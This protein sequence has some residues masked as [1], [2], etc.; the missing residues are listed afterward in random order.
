MNMNLLH[1]P[2]EV[3]FFRVVLLADHVCL[4][5]YTVAAI[6][7]LALALRPLLSAR[8]AGVVERLFDVGAWFQGKLRRTGCDHHTEKLREYV[9]ERRVRRTMNFS[10]NAVH[11]VALYSVCQISKNRY[12]AFNESFVEEQY[13]PKLTTALSVDMTLAFVAAM[14]MRMFPHWVGPF[15][16]DFF[17]MVVVARVAWQGHATGRYVTGSTP[18]ESVYLIMRV[19]SAVLIGNPGFTAFLNTV[20]VASRLFFYIQITTGP[21]YRNL[22]GI[23][24][25]RV[26]VFMEYDDEA[27]ALEKFVL[28]ECFCGLATVLATWTLSDS[29]WQEGLAVLQAKTASRAES[30]STC[31]LSTLCDAVVPTSLNFTLTTPSRQLT[32]FFMRKPLNDTYEGNNLLNLFEEEDRAHVAEQLSACL[33]MPGKT[34]SAVARAVDGGG[35]RQTARLYCTQYTDAEDRNG[36][37]IGI[38][39]ERFDD[40]VVDQ[41]SAPP[42]EDD[43]SAS[44]QTLGGDPLA[45]AAA[46]GSKPAED[47]CSEDTS[48]ATSTKSSNVEV[49]V[50]SSGAAEVWIDFSQQHLPIL[51][52]SEA[53]L[54]LMGTD[55]EECLKGWI[56]PVELNIMRRQ[57]DEALQ[58]R[59]V[60][61]EAQADS[62]Q[63]DEE[64]EEEVARIAKLENFRLAPRFAKDGDF[65]YI[66]EGF[67]S[68][69]FKDSLPAGPVVVRM[70]LSSVSVQ[71][72][73]KTLGRRREKRKAIALYRREK[74]KLQN[75]AAGVHIAE[76]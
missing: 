10:K 21:P 13:V 52:A 74:Q 46:G 16:V 17:H 49:V 14:Y 18:S 5:I 3:H 69:V 30:S 33:D 63:R 1:E 55:H 45:A 76:L 4:A 32:G 60:A 64:E 20:L 68:L 24:E 11:V 2:P 7:A 25:A 42:T 66:V 28:T 41:W 29:T 57:V 71:P 62:F 38:L 6:R 58:K 9:T 26:N 15:T 51:R 34:V 53:F 40:G 43:L 35:F 70:E 22:E 44:W 73:K 67:A 8:A 31:L 75:R 65:V 61:L 37:M 27:K 50:S 47:A 48:E 23:E 39:E 56:N 72:H 19:C 12:F 54:S 36:F 59:Q